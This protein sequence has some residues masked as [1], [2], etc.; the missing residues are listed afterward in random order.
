MRRAPSSPSGSTPHDDGEAAR[1]RETT[2]G[3]GQRAGDP[4]RPDGGNE[5]CDDRRSSAGSGETHLPRISVAASRRRSVP[6]SLPQT[7]PRAEIPIAHGPGPRLP[8][9]EA[10]GRRPSARSEPA[11]TGRHPKPF[12]MPDIGP[13][14]ESGLCVR[15]CLACDLRTAHS[16]GN[17]MRHKADQAVHPPSMVRLAPVM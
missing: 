5:D 6:R 9:L 4:V 11:R 17:R 8:P 15:A 2:T 1:S 14:P 10:F 3:L 7:R 16:E 13:L 12:T